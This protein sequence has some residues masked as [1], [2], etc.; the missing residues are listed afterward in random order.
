MKMMKLM[1]ATALVTGTVLGGFIES[2]EARTRNGYSNRDSNEQFVESTF[3]LVDQTID[4]QDIKEKKKTEKNKNLSFFTGAIE[5]FNMYE[6]LNSGSA[7]F[8]V[9]FHKITQIA[10][11]PETQ[12]LATTSETLK[13]ANLEARRIKNENTMKD[14]GLTNNNPDFDGDII[15]YRIIEPKSNRNITELF[16]LDTSNNDQFNLNRGLSDRPIISFPSKF[17]L[18]S[19]VNDITYIKDNNLLGLTIDKEFLNDFL[20]GTNTSRPRGGG[21][22]EQSIDENISDSTSVP[23]SSATTTLLV[24]GVCSAG[25]LLKR[26]M[27]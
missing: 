23:E 26:K 22:F 24:F 18:T 7:L 11:D 5:N 2:T 1:M 20:A 12:E 21:Y 17:S 10:L 15:V 25:L 27:V 3:F 14:L 9:F 13:V 16:L 19:A 4:G 6:S 8:P